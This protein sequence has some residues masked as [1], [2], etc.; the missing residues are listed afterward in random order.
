LVHHRLA[1]RPHHGLVLNEHF[2]GDGAIIYRHAC[3]LGCESIVSKRLGPTYRSGR[4]QHWIKVKNPA[5]PAGRRGLALIGSDVRCRLLPAKHADGQTEQTKPEGSN[6][7][8]AASIV[9]HVTLPPSD[10]CYPLQLKSRVVVM[11]TKNIYLV[12]KSVGPLAFLFVG[13]TLT[14]GWIGLLGY[15]LLAL[16]GH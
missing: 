15:G 5:A 2:N 14:V 7:Q 4:T 1:R 11:T 9:T 16:I 8:L 12:R 10:C 3:K 6:P 13:L